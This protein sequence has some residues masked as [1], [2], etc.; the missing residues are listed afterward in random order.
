MCRRVE[1]EGGVLC[2]CGGRGG[3]RSLINVMTHACT[4]YIVHIHVY[5]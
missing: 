4:L 1:G 2:W 3:R 5:T